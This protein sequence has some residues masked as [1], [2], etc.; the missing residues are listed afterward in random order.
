MVDARGSLFIIS[1][2]SGAGKTSLVKALVEKDGNLH[3]SVSHTTRSPR[4]GEKEGSNYHFV[5][6]S[7]FDNMVSQGEFLE[8]AQVFDH[9]YGTSKLWVQSQLEAGT[10]VVLEI[11]W[12]GARQIKECMPLACA[13][14][15]LPP[16]KNALQERLMSRGQDNPEVIERRMDQAVNEMSHFESS[17]Y[18]VL[19]RNFEEALN[20]LE[21]IV[22]AQRLR[23]VNRSRSLGNILSDMLKFG[24]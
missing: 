7:F 5:K 10:D 23:T 3:A 9:F 24:N 15:I 21:V 6:K 4:P 2:P 16:S 18:L 14:F 8:S 1:A 19:N 20:E 22:T 13:I 17:D 11:D 12:Q